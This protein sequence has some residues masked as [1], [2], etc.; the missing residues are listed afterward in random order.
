MNIIFKINNKEYAIEVETGK[1]LKYHP[2][3]LRE[4]VNRLNKIYGDRWFFVMTNRKFTP[5]YSKFGP[6]YHKLNIKNK[7]FGI[8]K[9][10]EGA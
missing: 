1:S 6:T 7:I 5:E 4:K 9:I 10:I 8:T 2:K 3:Q